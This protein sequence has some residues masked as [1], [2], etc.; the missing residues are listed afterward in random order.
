MTEFLSELFNFLLEHW[1]LST[2]LVVLL[3]M[4]IQNEIT[5][6]VYG[7]TSLP[8]KDLVDLMNS[9]GAIVYDL[10]PYDVYK[11]GHILGSESITADIINSRVDQIKA[12]TQKEVVLA[13]DS[14][15][16]SPK[17]GRN[18]VKLGVNK[19][20]Y[21]SGGIHGWQGKGYPLVKK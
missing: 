6:T 3:G 11:K 2:L 5:D 4:L 18:L 1:F 12:N 16:D 10:R 20:N 8:A 7:I 17:I 13:C 19:I 9:N 15:I 14:G 21:L